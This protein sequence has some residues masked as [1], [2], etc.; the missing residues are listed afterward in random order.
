MTSKIHIA[1]LLAVLAGAGW[2]QTP[3]AYIAGVHPDRRPDGAPRL[4]QFAVTDAQVAQALRG[5][6][7]VAPANLRAVVSAGAWWEPMS[8]PGMLAPYDLRGLHDKPKAATLS[9]AG[10][11]APAPASR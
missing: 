10:D 6:E 7:G 5:V 1:F 11:A 3:G 8:H 2:S 9:G 4:T